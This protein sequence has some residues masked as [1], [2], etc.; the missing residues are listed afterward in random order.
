MSA[1]LP[2]VFKRFARVHP[3]LQI[4]AEPKT[5]AEIEDWIANS[6]ADVGFTFLPVQR[7]QLPSRSVAGGRAVAIVP[8]GHAL[9]ERRGLAPA[10]FPAGEIVLPR[11]TVRLRNLVEASFIQAGVELRP[12]IET[13]NAVAT[14]N[15]VAEGDGVAVIDPFAV[16]AIPAGKVPVVP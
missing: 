13:S 1:F 15:L 16:T 2:R 6:H 7:G 12:W 10:E 8:A 11:P 3:D 14:A 9:S 5:R 4:M